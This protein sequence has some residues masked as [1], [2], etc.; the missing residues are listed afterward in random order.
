MYS[1]NFG[2]DPE[3]FVID[4][5]GGCIPPAALRADYGMK[6]RGKTIVSGPDWRLIEDG[7]ATE[8]NIAPS[9]DLGQFFSRIEAAKAAAKELASGFGLFATIFPTVRF[10]VSKFWEGRDD[11]FR[12]CVRFGCDPDLDIYS[13]KYSKEVSAENVGERYGGGHIHMQA[14][15]SNPSLFEENY[16]HITKLMDILVGNTAVALK[17]PEST[18]IAAEKS[19]LKFYGRPGKIRL[20]EYPNG[21]KGIEYRTPSNFWITNINFASVLLT[22]M[23]VVFNLSQK[24]ADAS[25]IF[26]TTGD[27]IAP[28]NIIK[29]DIKSAV[30][31]L[32]GCLDQLLGMRYISYDTAGEISDLVSK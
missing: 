16:Y 15:E 10:D 17:R 21:F 14:P 9:D 27:T 22:M 11:T 26:D 23:N 4:P 20:Q 1:T 29:F 28:N 13:G 3:L 19:R 2:C 12:D 31:V 6:F 25:V 8:I 18:W 7:A 5:H 32:S 30:E 24:P